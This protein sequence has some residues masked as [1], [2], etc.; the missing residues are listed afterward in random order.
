MKLFE[1]REDLIRIILKENILTPLD[2]VTK[3]TT[4]YWID[5]DRIIIP[6]RNNKRLYELKEINTKALLLQRM[7]EKIRKEKWI[8]LP[9]RW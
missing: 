7:I 2:W 8:K 6:E 9:R 5:W 1:K 4:Q 3:D